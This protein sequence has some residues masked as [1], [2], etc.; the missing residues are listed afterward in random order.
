MY[1]KQT[2]ITDGLVQFDI[3]LYYKQVTKKDL[4]LAE[5]RWYLFSK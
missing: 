4:L 2:A 5:V 3:K 1:P